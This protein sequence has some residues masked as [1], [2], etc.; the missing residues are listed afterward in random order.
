[1]RPWGNYKLVLSFT[2]HVSIY[3]TCRLCPVGLGMHT[4]PPARKER[5]GFGSMELIKGRGKHRRPFPLSHPS[6]MTFLWDSGSSLKAIAWWT[7][8][9]SGEPGRQEA[10][11]GSSHLDEFSSPWGYAGSERASAVHGGCALAH[12]ALT[13][14]DCAGVG[15]WTKSTLSHYSEKQL[16]PLAGSC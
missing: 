10:S 6:A 8:I 1:M 11:G 5:P 13:L 15:T 9:F 7:R 4:T 16:S 2:L 3:S 12:W 14:A